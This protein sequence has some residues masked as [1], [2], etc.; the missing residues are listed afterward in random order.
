MGN[1]KSVGMNVD[2]D[3][4]VALANCWSLTSEELSHWL[5]RY[6]SYGVPPRGSMLR[7]KL[8]R[9]INKGEYSRSQLYFIVNREVFYDTSMKVGGLAN[10]KQLALKKAYELK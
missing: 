3:V 1:V 2:I 4:Y 6:Y 7:H 9:A 10:N 5:H 8:A